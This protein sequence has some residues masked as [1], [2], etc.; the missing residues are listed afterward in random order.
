[1]AKR[2]PKRSAR[3]RRRLILEGAHEVFTASSYAK[4][5]TSKVARAAGV[6]APALYRDFPSK[7][8][9]YLSTLEA[10]GPRL[11]EIWKDFT[12][13]E[14]NPLDAVWSIGLAY[15][16]HVR[17]RFP[18]MRLWFQALGEADDPDVRKTLAESFLR[19][20]DLFED[21]LRRGK[22]QGLVRDEVDAR[23]AAW[24]FMAIGLTMDLI[25]LLGCEEE[26]NQRKVESWG[27]LYLESIRSDRG[28]ST[29]TK[30]GT[31]RR[32]VQVRKSR[33]KNL[34]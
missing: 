6:S 16:D 5:N 13:S 19:A 27:C 21:N 12:T 26:L 11:L 34:R 20:V 4:V 18:V 32:T 24:H 1:M 9:L 31:A 15:Y 30:S 2:A 8:D 10:A 22:T 7:K 3:E 25:H 28:V 17:S 33:R 23:V 29:Q 14:T